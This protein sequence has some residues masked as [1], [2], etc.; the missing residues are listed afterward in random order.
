MKLAFY[1]QLGDCWGRS[2]HSHS[3]TEPCHCRKSAEEFWETLPS[4][5]HLT[6]DGHCMN[7]GCAQVSWVGAAPTRGSHSTSMRWWRVKLAISHYLCLYLKSGA[8]AV[9]K[10]VGRFSKA[11][12]KQGWASTQ[13][14]DNAVKCCSPA[15][16]RL[17]PAH[18]TQVLHGQVLSQVASLTA[19]SNLCSI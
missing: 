4:I 12:T 17:D 7:L 16:R 1:S 6:L 9:N 8:A 11:C 13:P 14:N 3:A 2:R 19:M 5:F 10:A 18:I 15:N